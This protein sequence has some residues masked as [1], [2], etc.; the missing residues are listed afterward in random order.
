[1]VDTILAL[2]FGIPDY[3]NRGIVQTL[4]PD[5]ASAKMRRTWNG[6]LVDISSTQ[7]R[8]YRSTISCSDMVPPALSGIWPGMVVVVD[9]MQ[10]LCYETIGGSPE[11]TVVSGSSRTEG[12]FTFYRP[13]LTM[14]I[15]S[16]SIEKD[17]WQA[18]VGWTLVLVEV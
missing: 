16:F 11:R 5:P 2:D 3:S 1:M 10:E 9:C 8:K 18:V 15:E 12:S 4:E 7:F 6:R 17:E 13:Q 14:R